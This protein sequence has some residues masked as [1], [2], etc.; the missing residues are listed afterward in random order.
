MSARIKVLAAFAVTAMTFAMSANAHDPK[1]FDRMMAPVPRAVPTNC[2][3]L[4]D[5]ANYWADLSN[6]EVLAL[7]VRCDKISKRTA[8]KAA[9]SAKAKAAPDAKATAAK[10]R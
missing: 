1:E 7:K 4:A 2:L 8:A 9:V 5:T 3:Q 10:K 6:A